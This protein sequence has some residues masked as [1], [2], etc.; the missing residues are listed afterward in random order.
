VRTKTPNLCRDCNAS[1]ADDTKYLCPECIAEHKAAWKAEHTRQP[2]D[3]RPGWL[4][5]DLCRVTLRKVEYQARIVDMS[6]VSRRENDYDLV[7]L[8]LTKTVKGFDGKP[9]TQTWLHPE[10]VQSYKLKKPLLK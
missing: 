9:I 2:G 6:D 7:Q 8:E 1:L 3:T 4:I 5:G 10:P